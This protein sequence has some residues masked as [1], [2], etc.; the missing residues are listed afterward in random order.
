MD[1][2]SNDEAQIKIRFN[3]LYNQFLNNSKYNNF[4]GEILSDSEDI[5]YE[6]TVHKKEYQASF[7]PKDESIKGI[8]WYKIAELGYDSYR[9]ITFYDN[10]MN[11]ANGEDL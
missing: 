3:T 5:S 9:I 6:I 11:Q 2:E 7:I 10:I 4:S 8:V 1:A